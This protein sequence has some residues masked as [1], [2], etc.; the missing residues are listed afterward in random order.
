MRLYRWLTHQR[1]DWGGKL[2]LLSGPGCAQTGAPPA[3]SI[4]SGTALALDSDS[5]TM[6]AA[7]RAG[8]LDFVVNSLDEALRALKNEVRQRRPLS[9]GLIA[10]VTATLAEMDERGIVPDLQLTPETLQQLLPAADEHRFA[11]GDVSALRAI[12]AVL[13]AAIPS[14][15]LIRHRWIERAPQFLR[16]A[17]SGGRRIWL[18]EAELAALAAQGVAPVPR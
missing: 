5:A 14:A 13:L 8:H 11:A 18:S 15:D 1:D 17:R 12:D 6:K 9:V 3:V 10:D 7:Q 2:V 4:A 16:E